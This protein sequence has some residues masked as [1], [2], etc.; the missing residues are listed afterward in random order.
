MIKTIYKNKK[1]LFAVILGDYQETYSVFEYN[2]KSMLTCERRIPD[3]ALAEYLETK[4]MKPVTFQEFE[5]EFN[6]VRNRE[7]KTIKDI[8]TK[9]EELLDIKSNAELRHY[10]HEVHSGIT[11]MLSEGLL[12]VVAQIRLHNALLTDYV[13]FADDVKAV[14]D[15]L[16]NYL[17]DYKEEDLDLDS[18]YDDVVSTIYDNDY[19]EAIV[20]RGK[21]QFDSYLDHLV[22]DDIPVEKEDAPKNTK[23]TKATK[24]NEIVG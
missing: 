9:T 11:P 14:V 23:E 2:L 21:F 12:K 10:V 6:T 1:N 15:D 3:Y 13:T 8:K 5:N 4:G 7:L 24:P 18:K 16:L 20:K 22:E 17:G 19:V